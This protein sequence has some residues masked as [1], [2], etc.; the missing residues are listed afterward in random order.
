MER[1]PKV[2]RWRT[3]FNQLVLNNRPV[4]SLIIVLLVL[5]ILFMFSKVTWIFKPLEDFFKI[6]G[7]PIILAGVLYYLLNPLVDRLESRFK[8]KRVVSISII[9]VGVAILIV[10]GVVAVIPVIR[11][12]T[13]AL[14][15]NW[16]DY[17][18]A[19]IEKINGILNDPRLGDFQKQFHGVS[20]ETIQ[21]WSKKV[22]SVANNTV[23]S[24]GSV[25]S[26]IT[27]VVIGIITMPFIL[28]YLL[29]DGHDLPEYLAK[30]FPVRY[31]PQF[32]QILGEINTQ[33]SQYIRGQLVV[34]FFVA[35]MFFIGY[36]VIGLKFALTLA[37]AAGFLNLI[38]Y[39]GSFLAMVPSIVIGA[40]ISPVMLVKVLIVFAIEQT[41]E[42]RF[43]SPLVLGSNLAIHPVTILVVLLASGQMFGL[44]GVI[45]G[46]P[47]YAVLKVL[48]T[49]G[50]ELFKRRVGGYEQ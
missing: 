4:V 41:L 2:P 33:L 6:V 36:L 50:F 37:V 21:S 12:Q 49:H 3:W 22:T 40:F 1:K 7:F 15:Q 19:A 46:I 13:A 43:I 39:L 18:N 28:F 42:G 44:V 23:T 47:A 35:L 32:L 31:R 27:K 29:R 26:L 17:W 5:L 14:I 38:P 9:F 45:F 30:A 10:A 16:P 48:F 34:A 25:L 8:M 20:S 24:L 11:E